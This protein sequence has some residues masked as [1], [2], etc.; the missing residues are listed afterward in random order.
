MQHNCLD[1]HTEHTSENILEH[2]RENR[3]CVRGENR[4]IIEHAYAP[5]TV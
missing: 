4:S 1:N 5:D 2:M 3:T